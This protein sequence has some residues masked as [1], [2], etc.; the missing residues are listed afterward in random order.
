MS[1][2]FEKIMSYSN[3]G[4]ELTK[5]IL[6]TQVV[7]ENKKKQKEFEENFVFERKVLVEKHDQKIELREKLE[8]IKKIVD[9]LFVN[10]GDVMS[11][12]LGAIDMME[13]NA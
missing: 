7:L 12:I 3:L 1:D 11:R 8:E 2:M 5:Q 10:K 13:E 6:I 4:T 9:D